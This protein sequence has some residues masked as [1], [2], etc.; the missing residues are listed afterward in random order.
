MN[1]PEAWTVFPVVPGT[2][3]PAVPWSDLPAGR[4]TLTGSAF[5]L[6]CGARS[7]VFVL[8]L[9]V[10]HGK[11][12]VAA[13]KS[14]VAGRLMPPTLVAKTPSGGRHLYYRAPPW[15]VKTSVDR[16]GKGIDVRGDGG[17]VVLPPTEG[18]TW[19]NQDP[20]AE[21]PPW[22]LDL[23]RADARPE[24]AQSGTTRIPEGGRNAA[25]SSLAGAMRR[26]GADAPTILAALRA[27]NASCE[28]PLP[29]EE[30]ET[31]AKSIARYAP[32]ETRETSTPGFAP[33]S[34]DELLAP[35]PAPNHLIADLDL[36]PGRPVQLLGMGSAGKSLVG[37]A[38]MLA[39]VTGR[40]C[41]GRFPVRRG[42]CAWVDYE[43]GRS[44][45]LRRLR[46]LA[47]AMGVPWADAA[48]DVAFTSMPRTYLNSPDAE[49][50]L[51][52]LCEGR[53]ALFV[54]SLRRGVPGVDEND[55]KISEFLQLLLRVSERTGCTV[56]FL[57]HASTKVPPDGLDARGTGRGSSAI[58][59]G[60]GAVFHLGGALGEPVSV[61]QTRVGEAGTRCEDF[62]LAIRDVAV[63]D[64]PKGGLEVAW[65]ELARD[66]DELDEELL[67]VVRGE[68]F[69]GYK[70]SVRGA[71]EAFAARREAAGK[72][73]V[74]RER[75][76]A[77]LERLEGLGKLTNT[78]VGGRGKMYVVEG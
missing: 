53:A 28:P 50:H 75:I 37:Q 39:V 16:L 70:P 10:K 11:D 60:S 76:Y 38:M 72:K 6:A 59:D 45:S 2:K 48:R 14:L 41:F 62:A 1:Y 67:D 71:I 5:G 26:Q 20:V 40:P 8:D 9:D 29:P 22:L 42:R 55:S 13:L 46:R 12:G 32:R 44:A 19:V 78:C 61:T 34:L 57:H 21:A 7:G 36:G 69:K 15:P 66:P 73:G 4:K 63:G 64:D 30:L 3:R 17:Y 24:V 25:M 43:M 35:V 33:L 49:D 74:K 54:D 65:I 51:A 52:A 77:A 47:A 23:V 27:H 68:N 56:V 18:Y 31:I 58:Y